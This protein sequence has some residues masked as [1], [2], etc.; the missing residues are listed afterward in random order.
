VSGVPGHRVLI[1]EDDERTAE[2][3]RALLVSRGDVPVVAHTV[4]DALAALAKGRFC[5][6]L[7]DQQLPTRAGEPPLLGGGERILA[8]VRAA[9]GRRHGHFH[10]LPV[11][12]LTSYSGHEDFVSKMYDLGASAF[13]S[14]PLTGN[15]EKLLDKVRVA[16]ERAGRSAHEECAA[17]AAPAA[18]TPATPAKTTRSR[19]P[20]A[21]IAGGLAK[22]IGASRW[23]DIKITAIDGHT[24]RVQCGKQTVRRTYVDL[25]F[26]GANREPIK[27]WAVLLALC[28]GH[29][30]FRWKR[31]GSYDTAK[32]AVSVVQ[33]L[34]KEAFSLEEN[35]IERHSVANAWRARFF[36]SSE[37]ADPDE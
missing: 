29:G 16:L 13:M 8:A 28:A 7:L 6:C 10:V 26:A 32:N 24:L 15:M 9:D 31:F 27:K 11:I 35:P 2:D 19:E 33:K 34:L 3:L 17:L 4:E 18:E 37:I 22:E 21:P 23:K 14:K 12:V 36:A 20:L 5:Y 25:G 1:V 30:T